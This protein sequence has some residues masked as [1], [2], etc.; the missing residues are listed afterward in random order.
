MKRRPK[1]QAYPTLFVDVLILL[2]CSDGAVK[3]YSDGA[4]TK[5][6]DGIQ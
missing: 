3:E 6:S 2:L 5:Y 4:V 1:H